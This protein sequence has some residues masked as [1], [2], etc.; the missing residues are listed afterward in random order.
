MKPAKHILAAALCMLLAISTAAFGE[1]VAGPP[2][3]RKSVFEL[4]RRGSYPVVLIDPG[5]GTIIEA[6]DPAIEFYGY[7]S[8]VGMTVYEINAEMRDQVSKEMARAVE[9][10]TGF[11]NLKH[12][13]ADGSVRDV[14]VLSTPFRIEE[15]EVLLSLVFDETERL[16]A[17]EAVRR[18]DLS[19]ILVVLIALIVQSILMLVMVRNKRLR[20]RAESTLQERERTFTALFSGMS[21]MVAVH[22]FVFDDEGRRI[23]YRIVECNAAFE[24]VIGLPAASV[25]G[26]RATEIYGGES[27]YL[28]E[29]SE[30]AETGVPRVLEVFY[31]PLEKHFLISV[32][33]SAKDRFSTLTTDVTEMKRA[34]DRLKA[35]KKE[36][37]QIVYAASHDLR[38]PLVN[39]EGYSREL[40]Y[41]IES[42]EEALSLDLPCEEREAAARVLLPDM[43]DSLRRIR[44]GAR[45]MDSLLAGLLKLSRLRRAALNLDQLDMNSIV[46]DLVTSMRFQ[47]E[48]AGASVTVGNLPRC[49]GDAV[50][51]TQVFSN[52][53]NNALNFLAPAR[54][55]EIRIE[56][57]LMND[58]SV[59]SVADNGTGIAPEHQEKV[60]ELF[61]R[62]NPSDGSGEGLGL[63]IVRQ[64]LWMMGGDVALES[65]L[66]EGSV[67]KVSMPTAPQER[68]TKE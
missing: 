66:G 67:F 27:P 19:I 50:Q 23:D 25:I 18:R 13:L 29:Y 60:F 5:D 37:E 26:R 30:V 31:P 24:R 48:K 21:E 40:E 6:N 64:I 36:L 59:Y 63:T 7:P 68:G 8:L 61:H 57:V 55:G 10:S 47:I 16:A 12:L 2:S 38:S 3:S 32:V 49:Y 39:V 14:G 45:Q 58:W 46:S 56:G 4:F 42:L 65:K 51:V 35:K 15:G 17:Q 53:L 28:A 62:L 41:S 34:E 11:F 54:P 43:K 52:L 1:S 33:S 22:R 20:E 9:R 44:S